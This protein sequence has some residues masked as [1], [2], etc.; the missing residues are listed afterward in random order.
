MS[1]A[2]EGSGEGRLRDCFERSLDFLALNRVEGLDC[3]G[4]VGEGSV[5]EREEDGFE[6]EV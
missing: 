4:E 3:G 5:V 2:Y 6:G 1:G